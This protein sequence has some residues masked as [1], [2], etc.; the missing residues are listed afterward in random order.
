MPLPSDVPVV[1]IGAGLA[2]AATAFYLE[3]AGQ[4]RP[5]VLERWP[6]PGREASGRSASI[7]REQVADTALVPWTSRGAAILRRGE[8]A[9]FRATGL[10]LLG[11]GDDDAARHAPWAVGPGRLC[12][13]DGVVDTPA[14]LA[15]FLTGQD[16]RHGVTV[17]SIREERGAIVV[18]TTA[19]DVRAAVVVNAAGAWA[20]RLGALPLAPTVRH[21]FV[22]A[23]RASDPRWPVAWDDANG[24]YVRTHGDALLACA[25]DESA[26]NPGDNAVR[27]DVAPLL[28]EKLARFQP[29]LLPLDVATSWAG[30]RTFAPDRR[31]VFGWDAWMPGLFWVAGL[32]GHGVTAAAALGEAAA[33][34]IPSGPA[35]AAASD[36]AAISPRRFA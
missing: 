29:G 19:G 30:Q 8:L 15:R 35:V 2:G 7:V 18:A 14:L 33:R 20:G 26:A 36:L 27:D 10:L 13:D 17:T 11:E 31:F 16:V 25:C 3:R 22:T 24:F 23:P 12:P 28:R 5:L 4:P 6:E 34:L 1:I 9:P 21:L 32:G